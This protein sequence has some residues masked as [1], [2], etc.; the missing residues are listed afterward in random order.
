L[1]P[2]IRIWKQTKAERYIIYNDSDVFYY[3]D[4]IEPCLREG[5]RGKALDDTM[6]GMTSWV[7]CDISPDF[8]LKEY[9]NWKV[10][11]L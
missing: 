9:D 5:S 8:F 3:Q 1:K 10:A 11:N 4:G 2:P 7:K 6:S